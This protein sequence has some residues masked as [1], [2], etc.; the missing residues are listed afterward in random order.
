MI[1]KV[2]CHELPKQ[3]TDGLDFYMFGIAAW[4]FEGMK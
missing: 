3:S 2:V 1:A 4:L